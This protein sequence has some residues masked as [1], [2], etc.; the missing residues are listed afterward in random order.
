MFGG[1]GFFFDN[2]EVLLVLAQGLLNLERPV[3]VRFFVVVALWR[4]ASLNDL[5]TVK[6][7]Q[8]N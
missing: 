7:L 4:A 8:A 5:G 3:L 6:L 2:R 1:L